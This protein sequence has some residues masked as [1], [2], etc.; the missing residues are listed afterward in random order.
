MACWNTAFASLRLKAIFIYKLNST[1]Y[2][3]SA[4][5]EYSSFRYQ[6]LEETDSIRLLYLQPSEKHDADLHRSL[7]HTS[8][9]GRV[10][11]FHTV[12]IALS[13]V[14][15][16]PIKTGFTHLDEHA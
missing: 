8:I 4:S 2:T 11:D 13:Y 6:P 15:E 16:D 1:A 12:F 14:C 5:M 3:T 9:Y 10:Y 7:V